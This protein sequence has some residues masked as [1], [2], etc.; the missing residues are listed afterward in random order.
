MPAHIPHSWV[1]LPLPFLSYFPILFSTLFL[2]ISNSEISKMNF[3]L[4]LSISIDYDFSN[5]IFFS[6]LLLIMTATDK[7]LRSFPSQW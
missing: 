1:A 4:S 2:C 3:A 5:H 7:N 6:V